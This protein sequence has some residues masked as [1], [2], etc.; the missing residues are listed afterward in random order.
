VVVAVELVTKVLLVQMLVEMVVQV[1]VAID[2]CQ[3][4]EELEHLV[5]EI[6]VEQVQQE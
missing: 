1:V 5:K 3:L 4:L 2:I 6:M